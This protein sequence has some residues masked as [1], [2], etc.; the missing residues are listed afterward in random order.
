M[1]LQCKDL[2]ALNHKHWNSGTNS[3]ACGYFK[4][5]LEP[6]T[7]MEEYFCCSWSSCRSTVASR[8]ML[9][10]EKKKI[11]LIQSKKIQQLNNNNKKTQ[12]QI[13]LVMVHLLQGKLKLCN[14]VVAPKEHLFSWGGEPY[15]VA[16]SASYVKINIIFVWN[17]CNFFS[18]SS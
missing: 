1:Y 2:R 7:Q 5:L 3:T 8:L 13:K 11:P 17:R 16:L 12:Q 10:N 4:G 9:E 6:C 15:W 18:Y 14:G